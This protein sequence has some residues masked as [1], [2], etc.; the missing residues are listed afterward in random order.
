MQISKFVK[1]LQSLKRHVEKAIERAECLHD[2][3]GWIDLPLHNHVVE[4][5]KHLT[6]IYDS[7]GQSST[8]TSNTQNVGSRPQEHGECL[9]QNDDDDDDLDALN[10]DEFVMDVRAPDEKGKTSLQSTNETID[11]CPS[12]MDEDEEMRIRA[13]MSDELNMA[14]TSDEDGHHVFDD[15]DFDADD[16]GMIEEAEKSAVEDEQTLLVEDEPDDVDQPDD[17]KY[18]AVLKQYFGY[19]KFRPFQWKIINS[20]LNEKRDNCVIMATGYGKSLT[21]QFPSVFT[22]RVSII[23]SPLISLM[24]D[25]VHNLEASNI[26]ACFLGSA[27]GSMG[28]VKEAM[29]RG[30]YRIVYVTPEYASTALDQFKTLDKKVGLDLIAIDEAH[31]VS[32][33]GHDFRSSYRQL[34][35]LKQNFPQVPILAVTATATVEVRSDICRSL[36]LKNP[37]M[38]CTGFDRPNL[39]L[40]VCSKTGDIA[41]DLKSEMKKKGNKFYFDGSTII[42]C[43]TKKTT[44]DVIG[45]LQGLRVSCLPYHASLSL[46]ARKKAH[47]S[48]LNDQIEVVVATV[49][50]GM[51]IDK[52]DVR[53]VIH[54]GAPKDIESYYQEIG[55]AGRDGSPSECTA[56]F[57]KS[58]FNTCRHFINEIKSEKFRMHKLKML[59]KLEQYLTTASCRRRILLSYFESGNLEEIGGSENCCDCCRLNFTRLKHG[60]T[61]VSAVEDKPVDYTREAGDLFK[62]IQYT[63]SRFGLGVPCQVLMGSGVKKV[64]Q[65]QSGK[66]FGAGKYKSLKFWNALGRCLLYEGYLREKS[67]QS[68]YG[69]TVEM[70]PKAE[71]WYNKFTQGKAADCPLLLTPSGDLQEEEQ[72]RSAKPVTVR[73][74]PAF[75]H[76]PAA[77]SANSQPVLPALSAAPTP[78]AVDERT[79]RLQAELYKRL[80]KAR[81]DEA[82][83]T[84]FTPHSIASNR[85]LLDMARFRPGDTQ[86]LLKIEDFSQVKVNRFGDIFVKLI[87]SFCEQNS[88]KTNDFP[89]YNTHISDDKSETFKI[90]LMK[91]TETQRQSYIMFV[92]QGKSIEEVASQR[93]LKTST[94]ITHLSEALKEGLTVDIR[95]LGVTEH[96]EKLITDAVVKPP[97]KGVISSLTR[98]KDELPSY[99]EYNHI[100]LVVSALTAR[101]GQEVN[102]NGELVLCGAQPVSA[103]AS[104]GKDSQVP[105]DAGVS[106]KASAAEPLKCSMKRKLASSGS[107][108]AD[109]DGTSPPQLQKRFTSPQ[110]SHNAMHGSQWEVESMS[111]SQSFSQSQ[112]ERSDSQSENIFSQSQTQS[113]QSTA[114][115]LP[116]WMS[117][118]SNKTVFKKKIK[119][120]S[121]F[122]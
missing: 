55:R 22:K 19:S 49:A 23:I 33:W 27:Q 72:T 114:R 110:S 69:C 82:E 39:Y 76:T 30:Q 90:D 86:S 91:I 104:P 65:F 36:N 47:T 12:D 29:F 38:T 68:G 16:L 52:P 103:S 15:D 45:A 13:E 84:G 81:S 75:P 40:S 83:E 87:S 21:F 5:T 44:E 115:K 25:Q 121:L 111:D 43:P 105:S 80:V 77:V 73:L 34:G 108:D 67:L 1:D 107:D 26:E 94:V 41:N 92:L 24:Q 3:D 14:K 117:T 64:Q 112:G 93:G 113:S 60:L 32:Q 28:E 61:N 18:Q 37:N 85:V 100:K 54:Y 48:F 6:A 59:A 101:H 17:P 89:T 4:C 102:N 31:C 42:Y 98:I 79:A 9:S 53:K 50:F 58:D 74:Q 119:S 78:P 120:N 57:S 7:I 95:K 35:I 88:L 62:A 2:D 8:S 118:S 99:V 11:R 20:V 56:I 96:M 10:F 66:I 46:S 106:S 71:F 97:V 51:G 70:T 116:S 109:G 122:K 63:G